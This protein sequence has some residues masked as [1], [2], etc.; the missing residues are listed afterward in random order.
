MVQNSQLVEDLLLQSFKK[1]PVASNN[2]QVFYFKGPNYSFIPEASFFKVRLSPSG[3]KTV[4][5][6]IPLKMI[7]NAFFVTLKALFFL[8]IFIFLF[9]LFGHVEKTAWLE[10]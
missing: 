1:E 3:K 6:E 10:R 4:L 2:E 7:K 9:W 5:F 8:K